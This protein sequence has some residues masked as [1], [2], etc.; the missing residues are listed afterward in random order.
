MASASESMVGI[1][2]PLV[3]SSSNNMLGLSMASS[4]NTIL[5]FCGLGISI[6]RK[7]WKVSTYLSFGQRSNQG[8]L[9]VSGQT[10]LSELLSPVLV[11]LRAIGILVPDKVKC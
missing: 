9:C 3:G 2:R 8:G 10:V 1:S 5:D 6:T 4:A 7:I 11:V